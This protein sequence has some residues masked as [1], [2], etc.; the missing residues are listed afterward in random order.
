MRP[1]SAMTFS[2][3]M[4]QRSSPGGPGGHSRGVRLVGEA[5]RGWRAPAAPAL[6][7]GALPPRLGQVAEDVAAVAV[8]DQGAGRDVDDEVVAAATV[9]IGGPARAAA[10]GPPMLLMHD[11]GK[12]V[13]AGH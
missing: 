7:A 3:R 12:A 13:G 4:S 5:E 1:A 2:S 11:G 8:D 6:S 10:L 9:A